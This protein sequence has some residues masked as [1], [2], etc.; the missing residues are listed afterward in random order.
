MSETPSLYDLTQDALIGPMRDILLTA[1]EPPSGPEFSYPVVDQA[2]SSSMW[3]WITKGVGNG[4]IDLGNSPYTLTSLD[5]AT[6][7]GVLKTGTGGTANAIVEGFYHQLSEDMTVSLPMP[8][9]GTTTYRVCLTHDPRN[10]D[11]AGGPISVQVYAGVPPTTFGRVHVVLWT[12]RRSAN[13]LLTDATVERIRPRVAPVIYV[14]AE[15]HKPDPAQQLWGTLCVVGQTSEIYRSA[16]LSEAG[17]SGEGRAWVN[18]TSPPWATYSDTPTYRYP[19]HGY[20]RAIQRQ[21]VTRRL[22]G[23]IERVSGQSFSPNSSGYLMMTLDPA[24]RP[25]REVRRV[26]AGSN[27]AS[28]NLAVINVSSTTGEVRAHPAGTMSWVSLDG[29]EWYTE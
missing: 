11:S 26:T 22:R 9:S 13:Q 6:N 4:V 17:E 20:R 29:V 14:W 3:K 12:V 10:G 28:P 2:V 1:A 24:D 19:G 5:N 25:A 7:T 18:V 15:D 27:L 8:S 16:N 21:G 23:R